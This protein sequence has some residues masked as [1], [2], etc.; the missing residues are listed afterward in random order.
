MATSRS[1]TCCRTTSGTGTAR[2]DRSAA[3]SS[4][5]N[6]D[7]VAHH[8]YA[9]ELALRGEFDA[10]LLEIA[11]ARELDPYS[12]PIRVAVGAILYFAR[13]D[14]AARDAYRVAAE[15]D[16][17]SGLLQRAMAANFDRL[18]RTADAVRALGRWLDT[19]HPGAAAEVSRTYEAQGMPGVLRLLI[20][21]MI[22]RREAGL[23]E[24]ATHIGE[25]YAR[26]GEREPAFHWLE[27][28]VRE[29]DTELN[30]LR[31]DPLFD[32]L[33]GDP[34]FDA[35]LDKVGLDSALAARRAI[36]P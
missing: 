10:A 32:P 25:L 16:S 3:A 6:N 28:A 2:R 4:L 30:R 34:R 20:G 27:I 5:N 22:R 14:S 26:L 29:R 7:A 35:L 1:R 13:R 11:R 36:S 17:T 24:P 19:E 21:G 31:V 18:G 33:R 9:H 23:Y 15:L 8:W 12:M